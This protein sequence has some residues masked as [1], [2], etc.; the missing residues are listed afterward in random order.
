M[1]VL[2]EN[3]GRVRKLEK[4]PSSNLGDSVGSN[5]T[6]ATDEDYAPA[7]HWR[8]QVAVTHPPSGIA[9][10]TPARRTD[11]EESYGAER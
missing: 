6:R 7:G 8:A 4:R 1:F 3:R 11:R 5:P 9:G 10:S 2:R